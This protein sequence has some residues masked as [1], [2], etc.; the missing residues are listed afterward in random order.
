MRELTFQEVESVDG[1]VTQSDVIS[2]NLAIIGIGAG[3]IFAGMTA[4]AWGPIALIGLSVAVTGT[5]VY[6]QLR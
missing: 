4:P 1:A 5:Y 6:E 3:A 2:T